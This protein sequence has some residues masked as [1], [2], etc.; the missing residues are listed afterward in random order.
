M[1]KSTRLWRRARVPGVALPQCCLTDRAAGRK[2]RR[3]SLLFYVNSRL[4]RIG[5]I[6]CT[7][8]LQDTSRNLQQFIPDRRGPVRRSRTTTTP[9]PGRAGRWF[10]HGESHGGG[11]CDRPDSLAGLPAPRDQA[12]GE[13]S[14]IPAPDGGG[15][16]HQPAQHAHV[17]D[18][19][20]AAVGSRSRSARSLCR[21]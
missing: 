2:V 9:I 6:E 11:C 5:E 1:D 7:T 19:L 10:D 17:H 12:T 3:S 16:R 18:R 8:T 20:R 15:S 21:K 13:D 4:N 14:G